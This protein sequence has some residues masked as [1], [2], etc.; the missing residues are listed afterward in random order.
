MSNHYAQPTL[1]APP[2]P[3]AIPQGVYFGI[4]QQY[5]EPKEANVT[6]DRVLK[7]PGTN[8]QLRRDFVAPTQ[9]ISLDTGSLKTNYGS[10]IFQLRT[11]TD[12]AHPANTKTAPV[13][14][15]FR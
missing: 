15:M 2:P 10:Y 11:G 4:D 5:Y 14:V 6:K 12:A 8:V 13:E 1:V 7:R 3:L 9:P